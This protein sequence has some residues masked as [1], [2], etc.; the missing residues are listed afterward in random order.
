MTYIIAY[1]ASLIVF[2]V[3]DAIWL[4]TMASRLYR[5]AL[6]EILLDDLRLVPALA[7]YFLY[8]IG[9]VVFAAIPA[10]RAESAATAIAYG[11]LFG[12]LAY[13]TYDLT[14]YATLRNWTLQITIIDLVYG[15]VVAALTSLAA[16][17]AIRA[18]S[19]WF[20]S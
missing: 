12:F 6:G 17:F 1:V 18:A 16:Y 8:P 7:F 9:L 11:A 5:P 10:V 19:P 2:G 13:A 14:N 3:L 15:A 4:T 20:G